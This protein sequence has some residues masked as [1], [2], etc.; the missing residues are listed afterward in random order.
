MSGIRIKDSWRCAKPL[1]TFWVVYFLVSIGMVGGVVCGFFVLP[2]IILGSV[3]WV[4]PD[5]GPRFFAW[6]VR[7]LLDVQ[8]WYRGRVAIP[9]PKHRPLMIVANHRSH[10]DM[11]FLLAQ[12]PGIR[13][14]SKNTLFKV[15]FLGTMMRAL[16]QIPVTRHSL[17][18]YF[19]AMEEI[20]KVLLSGAIVGVFPEMTRCE[21]GFSGLQ[22]VHH[23]PFKMARETRAWV[24]PIVFSGTDRVW[25][26]KEFGI[27]FGE[28]VR[29]ETLPALKADDFDSLGS[30]MKEVVSQMEKKS[31]ELESEYG[32]P[33][34]SKEATL[35]I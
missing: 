30:L 5:L 31:I 4:P 19:E 2:L 15:P 27:R 28:T 8:P 32:S 12:V 1:K 33:L 13:V 16:R 20:K 29:V 25:P 17:E 6:G 7:R 34:I 3:G 24:L 22:K 18:S 26:K 35:E 21:I 9:L 10:L 14:L 11:F 23:A